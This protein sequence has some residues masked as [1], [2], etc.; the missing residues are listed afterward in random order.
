MA[1]LGKFTTK[2][3]GSIY[4]RV[5]LPPKVTLRLGE[6]RNN[7][8][9]GD[10]LTHNHDVH[11]AGRGFTAGC[12]RPVYEREFDFGGQGGEAA[13]HYLGNPESLADEPVKFFEYRASAVGLKV[14]LPS[15][16]GA[17]N[18]SRSDEP[19]KFPL[20]SSGAES[21]RADNL[22]LIEPLAGM[23]KQQPQH[24]LARGAEKGRPDGNWLFGANTHY[25]YDH[26]HKGYIRQPCKPECCQPR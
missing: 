7:I 8:I 11:V 16:H 24:R 10:L 9:H 5:Y 1:P 3:F 22:P 25:R 20:D 4:G 15:F 19:F 13:L 23:S 21:K 17:G 6:N 12:H 18:N 14:S 2:L 26:T